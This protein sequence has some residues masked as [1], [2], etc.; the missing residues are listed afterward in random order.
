[1][2]KGLLSQVTL[3]PLLGAPNLE[4]C[5]LWGLSHIEGH[6]KGVPLIGGS[7]ILRALWV[8]GGQKWLQGE[9]PITPQNRD[10]KCLHNLRESHPEATFDYHW[11]RVPSKWRTL[12]SKGHPL[13]AL[14]YERGPTT[15]RPPSWVHPKVASGWPGKV[16]MANMSGCV[17]AIKHS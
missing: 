3:K 6:L 13:G 17:V 7:F 9:T 4:A 15:C 1:M 10:Q 12:L 16:L 8:G 2:G 14:Q 11:L 5:K